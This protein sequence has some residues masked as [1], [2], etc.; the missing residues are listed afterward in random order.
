[1]CICHMTL[2]AVPHKNMNGMCVYFSH[3]VCM[4]V[5]L[6]TCVVG[7]QV[8]DNGSQIELWA[9]KSE[10]TLNEMITKHCQN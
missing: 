5:C 8:Y 6:R 9:R 4:C 7:A 10:N 2:L 3:I 1:M